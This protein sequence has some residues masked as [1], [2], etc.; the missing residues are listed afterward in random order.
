MVQATVSK[1]VK[2]KQLVRLGTLLVIFLSVIYVTM[3]SWR[4]G[5]LV[6]LRTLWQTP[7]WFKSSRSHQIPRGVPGN[8]NKTSGLPCPSCATARAPNPPGTLCSGGWNWYTRWTQNPLGETL[9]EFEPRPEHQFLWGC[10]SV[11]RVPRSQ[12]GCREFN[13]LQ[14]HHNTNHRRPYM[15][16]ALT[17]AYHCTSQEKT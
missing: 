4:N 7:C 11:G 6:T 9:C 13:P 12:C 8:F 1:T 10:N 3:R 16:K 15:P 17:K 2:A 5:I 14:L